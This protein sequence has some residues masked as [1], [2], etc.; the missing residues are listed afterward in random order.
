MQTDSTGAEMAF[1]ADTQA[2]MWIEAVFLRRNNNARA[3]AAIF[4]DL[5]ARKP[6]TLYWLGDIVALGYKAG[7]WLM[8]D[9]FLAECRK[10]SIDVHALLGNHDVMGRP[11]RGMRN[12]QRRFPEH[13]PTG[14]THVTD[15]VAVIMLNSNFNVL[16]P[17]DQAQQQVWYGTALTTLDNDPAIKSIIVTC[18]HAPYTNSRIVSSSKNVQQRFVPLYLKSRKAKLFITG[19]AHAFERF[20]VDGKDFLVIGGGGGLTQPLS[21]SPG[22]LADE[23]TE[24]K[25]H[26]HYLTVRRS[27]E[28][29]QV[30]SHR[31]KTDL[32]GFEDGYTFVVQ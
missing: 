18:H 10:E 27:G 31:L 19:H 3:T 2:P 4:T 17:T 15:S 8:I 11:N 21:T 12:F 29:L 7:T 5:V 1:I 6:K 30:T 22:R 26:F 24:Y 20:K 32:S 25:P 16:S 28:Q 9:Q 13:T 23:A 14:Y